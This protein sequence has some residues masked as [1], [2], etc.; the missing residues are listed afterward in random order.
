MSIRCGDHVHHRPSGED[1]LVAWCDGDDLQWCGWP[2]G[3]GRTADCDLVK[4]CSDAEHIKLVREINAH[5][6]PMGSRV[7][8]LYPYAFVTDGVQP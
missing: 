7:E 2:S 1:W 3:I 6:G 5:G 4:A 8:R